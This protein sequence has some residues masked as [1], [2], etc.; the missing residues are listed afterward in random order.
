MLEYERWEKQNKK[1]EISHENIEI[2]SKVVILVCYLDL[3]QNFVMLF[4]RTG[5]T[6]KGI[7]NLNQKLLLSLYDWQNYLIL[8]LLRQTRFYGFI[9][10]YRFRENRIAFWNKFYS[11]CLF[12]HQFSSETE[13]RDRI[14]FLFKVYFMKLYSLRDS[15]SPYPLNFENTFLNLISAKLALKIMTWNWR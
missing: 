14:L 4:F 11:K 5:F 9:P 7:H 8:Y 12:K 2:W 10:K 3:C 13:L 1:S 6:N 15:F